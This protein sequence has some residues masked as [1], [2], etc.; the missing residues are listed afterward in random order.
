MYIR[1]SNALIE[2]ASVIVDQHAPIVDAILSGDVER[3]GK[4]S[5][6]HN[7]DEGK[8]LAD[9]LDQRLRDDA[10]GSARV[11]SRKAG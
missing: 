1:S 10:A 3:S 7:L 11:R 6:Q 5:E 4:L 9:R 2:N 8:K